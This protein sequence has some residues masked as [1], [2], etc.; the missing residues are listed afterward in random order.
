MLARIESS[1]MAIKRHVLWL[2]GPA[3]DRLTAVRRRMLETMVARG[4]EP[5]LTA[6]ELIEGVLNMST[7]EKALGLAP[8]K[9]PVDDK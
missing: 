3:S 4:L 1:V 6:N 2:S 7:M 9:E 5:K 8:Q